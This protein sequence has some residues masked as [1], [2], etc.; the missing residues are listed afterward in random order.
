V[1]ATMQQQ[2]D[3]RQAPEPAANPLRRGEMVTCPACERS[4]EAWQW[5]LKR[6]PRYREHTVSVYR[7]RFNDCKHVFSVKEAG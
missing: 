4:G 6:A 2:P 7:C 5:S 3:T 1:I